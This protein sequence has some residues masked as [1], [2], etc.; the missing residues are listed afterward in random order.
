[1]TVCGIGVP[2]MTVMCVPFSLSL[3]M[4]FV[5]SEKQRDAEPSEN[6]EQRVTRPRAEG[7][8]RG[9]PLIPA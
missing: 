8:Q 9:R 2:K 4:Q 7:M 1:M 6:S 5:A 3:M